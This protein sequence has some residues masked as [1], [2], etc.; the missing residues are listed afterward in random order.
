MAYV[1][2]QSAFH[3]SFPIFDKSMARD[4]ESNARLSLLRQDAKVY[5]GVERRSTLGSL[6]AFVL[7]VPQLQRVEMTRRIDQQL[8]STSPRCHF[9][10]ALFNGSILPQGTEECQI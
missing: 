10:V 5:G 3:T 7:S 4:W 2:R 1:S 9:G 8:N 6:R